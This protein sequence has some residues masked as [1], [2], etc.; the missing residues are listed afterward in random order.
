MIVVGIDSTIRGWQVQYEH[1]PDLAASLTSK[2]KR[3]KVIAEAP[4]TLQ[5]LWTIQHSSKI[6]SLYADIEMT[7]VPATSTTTTTID[8]CVSTESAS[9]ASCDASATEDALTKDNNITREET[10]TRMISN[11]IIHVYTGDTTNLI[12]HYYVQ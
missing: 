9:V 8:E 4:V 3:E 11:S 12:T 5:S 6:N 1:H 10:N 7:T 2:K